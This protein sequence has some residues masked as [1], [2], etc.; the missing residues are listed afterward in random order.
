MLVFFA[1]WLLITAHWLACGW[2][3]LGGIDTPGDEFTH[4]LRSLYWCITTLATVGYGDIVPRTS[5]QMLYAM[6]VMLLGVGLY[7]YVVGNVA[8]LLANLDMAKRHYTENMERLGAFLRYRN[9]PLPLQHRLRDYYAYLWE[10]RMGYDEAAVLEDLPHGLRTEVA[11]HLRRD[12]IEQAPLFR[13]ASHEL[14]REIALQLHPVVYTPGDYVFRA[15]HHGRHMYFIGTGKVEVIAADGE[16][17][18]ATLK[19][20]DFFGEMAL[21]FSK[22]RNASVRA[23]D[24]CD[25][26]S[27]D[28]ETFDHAISRFPDFARHIKEEA[29]RRSSQ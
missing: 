20:G 10:N 15:G 1:F 12:F 25:L 19:A 11:L 6:G 23:V 8:N 27:L 22:A 5:P 14:V 4:Y 2:L 17:I 18:V 28:K 16:T 7:G 3:A 26:Y 9:I 29:E 13:N 24:Y 21:L